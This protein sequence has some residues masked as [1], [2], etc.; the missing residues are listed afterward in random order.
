VLSP[1]SFKEKGKAHKQKR[2]FVQRSG[3]RQQ[4]WSC[5]DGLLL[6]AASSHFSRRKKEA[7]ASSGERAEPRER[8]EFAS[9]KTVRRVQRKRERT[10]Q[11][12]KKRKFIRGKREGDWLLRRTSIF[13]FDSVLLIPHR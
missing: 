5:R 3:C 8:C 2:L 4:Q 7:G 12:D 6:V 11:S 1:S 9:L 10:G 13:P